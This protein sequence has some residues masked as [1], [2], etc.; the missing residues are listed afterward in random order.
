MARG[1]KL[2]ESHYLS[3]YRP[4]WVEFPGNIETFG[5]ENEYMLGKQ[6]S[7]ESELNFELRECCR[8]KRRLENFTQGFYIVTEYRS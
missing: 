4:L 6:V 8:M 7:L 1:E 5:V 3:F 2:T